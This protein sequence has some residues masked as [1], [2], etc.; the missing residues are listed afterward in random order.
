MIAKL[1][2]ISCVLVA[3][4]LQLCSTVGVVPN[5]SDSPLFV[6]SVSFPN[7]VSN[8]TTG[9]VARHGE[10]TTLVYRLVSPDTDPKVNEFRERLS[11]ELVQAIDQGKETFEVRFECY[12][13][14]EDSD[15]FQALKLLKIPV[16]G[17]LESAPI[18]FHITPQI[19]Q[20]AQKIP[21]WFTILRNGINYDRFS[22]ELCVTNS[23]IG[24]DDCSDSSIDEIK[25]SISSLAN[26]PA[27]LKSYENG[28]LADISFEFGGQSEGDKL[29]M[30]MLVN[31]TMLAREFNQVSFPGVTKVNDTKTLWEIETNYS[32]LSSV[33][34]HSSYL[35]KALS[36]FTIKP[37]DEFHKHL[38]RRMGNGCA[39]IT[40]KGGAGGAWGEAKA[41]SFGDQ[42]QKLSGSL[43]SSLFPGEALPAM[44][45]I[46]KEANS[47]VNSGRPLTISYNFRGARLPLQILHTE[48][49]FDPQNPQF[50]GMLAEVADQSN[51]NKKNMNGV[52]QVELGKNSHVAYLG[53]DNQVSD[54]NDPHHVIAS[55]SKSTISHV[56]ANL[57]Q[58]TTHSSIMFDPNVFVSYLRDNAS[59]LDIVYV[60]SHGDSRGWNLGDPINNFE[61]ADGSQSLI[62]L[63]TD[64]VNSVVTPDLL[65]QLTYDYTYPPFIKSPVVFLVACETNSPTL[66]A[67]NSSSFLEKFRS[68]GAGAIITTEAEIPS[69]TAQL[70][71]TTMLK[72][73]NAGRN[74]SLASAVLSARRSVYFGNAEG[75][76]D[77]GSNHDLATLLFSYNGGLGDSWLIM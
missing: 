20:A 65:E 45:L 9:V 23:I 43:Q 67:T 3:L 8:E 46:L 13:F 72:H 14:C 54:K 7:L 21:L 58:H 52:S 1:F 12:E 2:S 62:T 55:I 32:D 66:G 44:E 34:K 53:F 35:Y 42:L 6:H 48:N 77:E 64:T 39:V 57:P 11:D 18:S 69:D 25:S 74:V 33:K 68:L 40:H 16:R 71:S 59:T 27:Y 70:F 28:G 47:R 22:I 15:N 61:A 36:C 19:S 41:Q 49:S 76:I 10:R 63:R 29:I 37:N 4:T 75:R 31:D 24:D 5:L 30:R 38:T 73:M 51:M 50:L 26:D 60:Y 56:K 17:S